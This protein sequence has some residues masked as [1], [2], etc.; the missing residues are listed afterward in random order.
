MTSTLNVVVCYSTCWACKFGHHFDPPQA[1][2]WADGDEIDYALANGL[3]EPQ[4][5]CACPC[6]APN[7]D[8]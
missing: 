5:S 2:G 1:H 6:A 3:P 7:A 4:G 8:G